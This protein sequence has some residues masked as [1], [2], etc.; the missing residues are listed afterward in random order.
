MCGIEEQ[1]C[2]EIKARVFVPVPFAFAQIRK[3]DAVLRPKEA[4]ELALVAGQM[5]DLRQH[6]L[7]L[8][9]TGCPSPSCEVSTIGFTASQV[10]CCMPNPSCDKEML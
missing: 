4:S 10:R 2:N 6:L 9:R 5:L 3:I 1:S 7:E 8:C